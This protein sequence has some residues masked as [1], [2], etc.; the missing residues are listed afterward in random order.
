MRS[1][2]LAGAFWTRDASVENEAIRM[3]NEMRI[4]GETLQGDAPASAGFDVGRFWTIYFGRIFADYDVPSFL[5]AV[6]PA[7]HVATFRWLFPKPDSDSSR[8]DLK[9]FVLA[10]LL[11]HAGQR[12]EALAMFTALRDDLA[13]TGGFRTGGRLPD[14]TLAAL[15]RLSGK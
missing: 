9:R 8:Q 15:K 10:T 3:A 14:Q 1:L 6:S 2:Q 11:E 13:R 7:D 5:A 4:A 12:D